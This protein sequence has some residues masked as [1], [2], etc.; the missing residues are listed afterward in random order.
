M[1][2]WG[3]HEPEELPGAGAGEE[4]SGEEEERADVTPHKLATTIFCIMTFLACVTVAFEKGKEYLI[5]DLADRNTK[6]LVKGLFSELT[7][8]GFLSL[9]TFCVSQIGI[10]PRISG[11]VFGEGEEREEYLMELL[12]QI[13]FI[14]FAVMVIFIMQSLLLLKITKNQVKTWIKC[15]EL[16]SDENP[17]KRKDMDHIVDWLS[18]EE[19]GAAASCCRAKGLFNACTG[20]SDRHREMLDVLRFDAMREEFITPRSQFPPFDGIE[21]DRLPANFD[22]AS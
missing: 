15:Q 22:Y 5:E 4:P 19:V 1:A 6:G 9:V 12:E 20:R 17:T 13:H 18:Q 2:F 3:A 10:L 14:I 8:L 21:K 7:V 11:H 16:C